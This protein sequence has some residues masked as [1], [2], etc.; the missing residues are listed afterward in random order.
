ML[1][2]PTTLINIRSGLDDL[3]NF[4][5]PP[6]ILH[7]DDEQVVPIGAA[8]LASSKLVKSV[9]LKVYAVS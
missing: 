5:M 2:R 3:K 4:D 8:A 9:T 6:L 7:G 1:Q